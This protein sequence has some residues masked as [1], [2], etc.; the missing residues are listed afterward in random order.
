MK[1]VSE[2]RLKIASKKSERG[3]FFSRR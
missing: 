2:K 1:T 3:A